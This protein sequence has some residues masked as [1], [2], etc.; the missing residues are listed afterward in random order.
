MLLSGYTDNTISHFTYNNNGY[1]TDKR[2]GCADNEA[3]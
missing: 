2:P 3:L 1:K